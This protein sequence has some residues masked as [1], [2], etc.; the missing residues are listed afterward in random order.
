MA[1]MIHYFTNLLDSSNLVD[2]APLQLGPTWRNGKPGSE[3]IS[4]RIDRFLAS[5]HLFPIL[6]E[7]KSWIHPSEISDHYPIC[8]EW[9]N[10]SRCHLYPFKFNRA[11]LMEKDF[12][13][14]VSSSC[15]TQLLCPL[16]LMS[17]L[18]CK[19]KKLKET[20]KAW[21]KDMNRTKAKETLE[22][23]RDIN[24]LITS[25]ASGI[26]YVHESSQLSSLKDKKYSL[27]T[28]QI[29]TWKLKIRIDWLNEGDANTKFFHSFA[30][31]RRASK[32][33]WG[34]HN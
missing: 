33:I 28:H 4:K 23:D 5:V 31:T 7:F 6:N 11:W 10:T 32:S 20:V 19:L 3:G 29:L 22:V 12:S 1:H 9:H 2:L 25:Q 26:L 34:L 15:N 30:S 18:T 14:I 16:D 8:I 17:T 27:L 13:E 24:T 21:E